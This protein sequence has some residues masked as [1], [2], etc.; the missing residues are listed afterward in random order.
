M[1]DKD[2]LDSLTEAVNSFGKVMVEHIARV[3]HEVNR[4]YCQALGD[5]SQLPWDEA[6]Q[7]QRNS[8]LAGV[9]S[10]LE[11]PGL[12]PEQSHVLWYQHKQADGWV[13][14]AFKDQERKT[15]PCMVMYHELPIEQ[16][17]K[18]HIFRAIVHALSS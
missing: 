2:F 17:A 11:N 6:P 8:C 13:Y 16:R 14:G 1:S 12:T 7:W 15:H 4:A 5:D 10:H 18:D 9:R 3:C